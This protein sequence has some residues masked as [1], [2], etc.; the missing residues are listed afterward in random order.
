[1]A[2][3]AQ[4]IAA[5]VHVPVSA[6]SLKIYRPEIISSLYDAQPNQCSTC[7]R[8]FEMTGVGREEKSRHLD[9]HFRT[10]QRMADPNLNRGH[11]RNWYVDELEWVRHVEFDPSTAATGAGEVDTATKPNKQAAEQFVR[12]PPGMTKNTCNICFEEMKSSYS[13][14]QQ[15]WIFADATLSNGKIVHAQCHAEMSKSLPS[16][17][18]GALSGIFSNNNAGARERSA[19]PDSTLGKRK[20]ESAMVGNGARLKLSQ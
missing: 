12:A 1:M 13:E 18:G 7:G 16:T 6:A 15:D 2:M 8:R 9:W 19:T 20:A 5:K 11:H 10:N 4:R 17:G 3:P 14:D